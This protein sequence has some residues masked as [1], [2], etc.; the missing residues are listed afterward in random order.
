MISEENLKKISRTNFA[1]NDETLLRKWS[2]T[3]YKISLVGTLSCINNYT[4]KH[5]RKICKLTQS[6]GY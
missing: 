3:Y 5:V 6:A 4:T 1:D 2:F